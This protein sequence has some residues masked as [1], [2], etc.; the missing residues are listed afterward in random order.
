MI[1]KSR[2]VSVG[3]SNYRLT[4]IIYTDSSLLLGL[5]HKLYC[6]PILFKFLLCRRS[7][8]LPFPCLSFVWVA[9]L[10]ATFY[11]YNNLLTP[12]RF[13]LQHFLPVCVCFYLFFL[14]F[15]YIKLLSLCLQIAATY[16]EIEIALYGHCSIDSQC[17]FFIFNW[18]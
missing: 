11:C 10:M 15:L 3:T 16:V 1:I 12:F 4:S 7:R 8:P 14:L 9:V 5:L 13:F 2:P 18:V 6:H 17:C